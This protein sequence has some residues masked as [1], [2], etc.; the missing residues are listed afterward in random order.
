MSQRELARWA[1][2]PKS[3]VADYETGRRRPTLAVARELL[4]ALGLAVALVDSA[5][6]TPLAVGCTDDRRDRG[7]RQVPPHLDVRERLR[8][9]YWARWYGGRPHDDPSPLT[10]R[11]SRAHRDVLRAHGFQGDHPTRYP[12]VPVSGPDLAVPT[13]QP[14]RMAGWPYTFELRAGDVDG[15]DEL[16]RWR[17]LVSSGQP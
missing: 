16:L 8:P 6:G 11:T 12:P 14:A 3:T 7:G 5:T 1:R 15:F 2:V 9:E 17:G 10:W 4:G 13:I